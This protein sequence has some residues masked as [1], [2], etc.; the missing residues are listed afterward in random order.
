MGT[1]GAIIPI[2]EDSAAVNPDDPSAALVVAY[3]EVGR[4]DDARRLLTKLV[5]QE[6]EVPLD[7]LWT[8]NMAWFAEAAIECGDQNSAVSILK[9]FLRGPISSAPVV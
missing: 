2:L 4:T 3:A 9:G 7:L 1:I 8:T 6:F 5:S